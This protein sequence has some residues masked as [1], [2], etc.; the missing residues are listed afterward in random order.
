MWM[1]TTNLVMH[2][3]KKGFMIH[4]LAKLVTNL[5]EDP[6]MKWGIDFAGPIELIGRYTKKKTLL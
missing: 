1:I 6:F 5:L 2:A 3:K 4:N